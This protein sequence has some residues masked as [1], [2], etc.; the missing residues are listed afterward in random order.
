[1]RITNCHLHTFTHDHT[2]DRY[3]P[4]PLNRLVRVEWIRRPLIWLAQKL[5]PERHSQLARWVGLGAAFAR[6]LPPK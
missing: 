5:D 4:W 6:S 2:P 1:M 3:V